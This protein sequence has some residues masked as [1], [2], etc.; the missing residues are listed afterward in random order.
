MYK[1]VVTPK[2]STGRTDFPHLPA[3][4]EPGAQSLRNRTQRK[5]WVPFVSVVGTGMLGAGIWVAAGGRGD[6]FDRGE[7]L[8]GGIIFALGGLL[9]IYGAAVLRRKGTPKRPARL[10]GITL[11]VNGEGQRRGEDISVT[12]TGKRKEDDRLE[13]GLVCVERYDM[14]VR[15]HARGASTV[16]R[17]TAEATVHEQWQPVPT[18]V[19][20]QTFVFKV[21]EDAP[22]SYEGDC[23]SYA[24]LASARALR[25]LRR[26]P[27]L[28]TPIW[29]L[30]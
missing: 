19:G 1:P 23:V 12:C 4:Y 2:P 9:C 16:L 5:L 7:E 24:W 30:P 10:R 17:Q 14:Q 6:E 27:R 20:E 11:T 29:V 15:V 18:A 28:Q 26:D 21:P 3:G 8:V 25:R 13:V 22:Y